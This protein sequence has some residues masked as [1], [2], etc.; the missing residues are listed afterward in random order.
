MDSNV[1]IFI[2]DLDSCSDCSVYALL[3]LGEKH[4][5]EGCYETTVSRGSSVGRY[6]Q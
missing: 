1:F 5:L 3:F 2:F 4:Q 6:C